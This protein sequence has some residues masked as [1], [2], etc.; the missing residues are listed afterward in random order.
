MLPYD[1][2]ALVSAVGSYHRHHPLVAVLALAASVLALALALRGTAEGRRV[3]PFLL[4]A[5]WLWIGAVWHIATF[6]QL[7]FA[8]PA[9]GALFLLQG[10][11]LLWLGVRGRL[12][13]ARPRGWPGAAGCLLTLV[14][15][16]A[17]PIVDHLR[18]WPWSSIRFAGMDPC[19]TAV[20]TLGI[21]LLAQPP[22]P[23]A[24]AVPA[25][26]TLIA[27]FTGWVLGIAPDMLLP[28]AALIAC[29]TA[30]LARR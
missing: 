5:C 7:N 12:G 8:A 3:V 29:P 27:A 9:Y 14:A 17:M 30:V 16:I 6:A 24:M 2:E 18:G 4:A 19:P 15:I 10:M 23:T 25:V 26:W 1:A 13:L 20:L 21:I 28:V 11:I 22:R